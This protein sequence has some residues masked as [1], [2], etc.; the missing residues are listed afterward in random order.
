MNRSSVL[1][2]FSQCLEIIQT[3]FPA[4]D[5]YSVLGVSK[6]SSKS[7]IKSGKSYSHLLFAS[8]DRWILDE[9]LRVSH[10]ITIVV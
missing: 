10:A 4:Q 6:N 7:E 5:Y 8:I 3:I 2:S 9:L 1:D